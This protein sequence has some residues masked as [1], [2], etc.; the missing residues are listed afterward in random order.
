MQAVPQPPHQFVGRV[1]VGTSHNDG[2]PLGPGFKVEASIL[3]TDFAG[4]NVLTL[5]TGE[6]WAP[7]APFYVKAEDP[8]TP[9]IQGGVPGQDIFFSVEGIAATERNPV[10]PNDFLPDSGPTNP[11]FEIAGVSFVDLFIPVAPSREALTP[12]ATPLV[13]TTPIEGLPPTVTPVPVTEIFEEI[14][15]T[16]TDEQI[17]EV[18]KVFRASFSANRR[19]ATEAFRQVVEANPEAAGRTLLTI[20]RD[21]GEG[22]GDII[23][24]LEN[25]DAGAAARAVKEAAETD[26]EAIAK[27]LNEVAKLDAVVA[28]GVLNGAARE[29][30][31]IGARL[32]VESGKHDT[33]AAGN[34]LVESGKQDEALVSTLILVAGRSDLSTTASIIADASGKDPG[35]IGRVIATG[36]VQ[37]AITMGNVVADSAEQNPEGTGRA[38]ASSA[39]TNSAATGDL[40]C[41]AVDRKAGPIGSA[42]GS[43]AQA[44]AG[45]T[46]AALVGP[47]QNRACLSQLG[48]VIPVGPWVPENGPQEGEDPTGTGT[49]QDVG[50][51][52]PIDN[53]L[54]RYA[55][56][57]VGAK[58]NIADVLTLPADVP[59]LPTGRINFEYINIE[60]QNFTNDD[61]MA[62]HV[63]MFVDKQWLRSN[64]VHEWS[65][66]FSRYEVDTNSWVPAVSKRIREDDER[67]FYTVTIP[68]FSLWAIHG[69]TEAPTVTFVES[70]LRFD[71][72]VISQ[73]DQSIVS[74]DVTNQTN[75]PA[76]YFANL[77]VNS[78]IN[79]TDQIVIGARATIT[80]D[81]PITLNTSGTY[82]IRVGREISEQPLLVQVPT[83]TPTATPTAVV[84]TVTAT[85][86]AV[87]ST[88]TATPTA[89]VSTVTATPTAVATATTIANPTS[90]PRPTFTPIPTHTPRP[91]FTSVPTR[92]PIPTF[93]VPPTSTP[94][95]TFTPIPTHTPR[96]IFTPIP[97]NTPRPISTAVPTPD[98]AT[99]AVAP[100]ATIAP[101]EPIL[102]DI[103]LSNLNPAS[104]D[105]IVV[106]IPITNPGT[107]PIVVDLE[108]EVGGVVV[109]QRSVTVPAGDTV[110]VT[111]PVIAP[112]DP[113]SVV[114]R[115]DSQT[116]AA[117]ITPVPPRGIGLII[118]FVIG[119]LATVLMVATVMVVYLRRRVVVAT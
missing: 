71:P 42:V 76:T 109:D 29:D 46:G 37:D 116:G 77:W 83:A 34:I 98:V 80:V 39:K 75:E 11:T 8:A 82:E 68:G 25:L 14:S 55:A 1:F 96:P 91:A 30:N 67:V 16:A 28:A 52:A 48:G 117:Q 105:E 118:G 53:I 44:D 43:S 81:F 33:A 85:P 23:I 45:S 95:P 114:V 10:N 20:A 2:V 26:A 27:T 58:T 72:P 38:L 49:W 65:M 100:V 31:E 108:V 13:P 36:A 103:E 86:T 18:A 47:A 5:A 19:Q 115:V 90:T 66:Q 112:D 7:S 78:Q 40:V 111:V 64:Q 70:N 99:P 110:R 89:V 50:S 102:G 69:S 41:V 9:G 22:A 88:V 21:S 93:A 12:I 107:A 17:K 32:I 60:P 62:A 94:R 6:Y 51:P 97:T 104:G 101:S 79:Q 61:L 92:T 24:A 15:E 106:T 35:V 57:I 73:Y 56:S 113:A 74:V 63:T 54:A 119:L 3:G 84:S 59:Q 87:V 4:G